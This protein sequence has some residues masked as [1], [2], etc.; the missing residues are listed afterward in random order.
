MRGAM[1]FASFNLG[2]EFSADSRRYNNRTFADVAR[3][4]AAIM[5]V[6]PEGYAIDATHPNVIYVAENARFTVADQRITWH[7]SS[8]MH[9]IPLRP[10]YIYI[11]L[12]LQ[13]TVGE[14]PRGTILATHRNI[15]RRCSLSQTLYC[16][17]WWQK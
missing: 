5:H 15:V 11:T 6:Q 10:G 12:R 1:A 9:S 2:E 13:S 8:G 14:A 7:S 17:R 16:E 4:Y 3:D